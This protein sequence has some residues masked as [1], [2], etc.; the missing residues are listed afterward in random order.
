[1]DCKKCGCDGWHFAGEH[2]GVYLYYRC[3][4][5][6]HIQKAPGVTVKMLKERLQTAAGKDLRDIK[7]LLRRKSG[8]TIIDAVPVDEKIVEGLINSKEIP[9]AI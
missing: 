8:I 7:Y 2:N 5:C 1:M 3:V 4:N 6:N 9:N